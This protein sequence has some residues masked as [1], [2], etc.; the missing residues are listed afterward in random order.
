MNKFNLVFLICILILN[1]IIA[2]PKE[3][4]LKISDNDKLIFIDKLNIVKLDNEINVW[5]FEQ[6]KKPI[7]L[8]EVEKDIY[9]VKTKYVIEKEILRYKID[10]VIY[11]DRYKNVVKSFHYNSSYNDLIYRYNLPIIKNSEMEL[12]YLKCIEILGQSNN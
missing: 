6:Y 1:N 12:I 2:Q 9:F 8:E 7:D 4:W 10:D 11:Y 5:V 3:D